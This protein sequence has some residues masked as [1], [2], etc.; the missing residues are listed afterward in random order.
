VAP[1]GTIH[2]P[3]PS[4]TGPAKAFIWLYSKRATAY[5]LIAYAQAIED[6]NCAGATPDEF[7]P[8]I[9]LEDLIHHAN[10]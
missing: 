10:P 9:Q 3:F 1:G 6:V 4:G 7:V 5:K 2:V 8:F